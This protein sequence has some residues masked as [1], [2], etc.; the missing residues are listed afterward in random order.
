[1]T[2]AQVAHI[3]PP[4]PFAVF[5]EFGQGCED[6]VADHYRAAVEAALRDAPQAEPV[7]DRATIAGLESAVNHLSAMFDDQRK[8]L[9]EVESVCGR[10][11]YGIEFED[12]DSE[13]IDKVRVHL[14]ATMPKTSQC[15]KTERGAFEIE[16]RKQCFQ[17]PTPEAYDLAWSMWQARA[18]IKGAQ[19][20]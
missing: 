11:D 8:L 15:K 1:M 12:G 18:A 16:L 2:P 10:D 7:G 3:T 9:V 6:R 19:H 17:K 14:A 20:E 4:L 13:L 5:D